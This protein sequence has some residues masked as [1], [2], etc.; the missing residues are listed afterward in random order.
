[1][2][3]P[4]REEEEVSLEEGK[5][6]RQGPFISVGDAMAAAR[7]DCGSRQKPRVDVIAANRGSRGDMEQDNTGLLD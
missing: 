3:M 5:L 7:A 1:M 2:E 6:E 4:E